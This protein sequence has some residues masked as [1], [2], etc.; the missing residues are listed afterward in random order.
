MKGHVYGTDNVL[1]LDVVHMCSAYK[2]SLS[3]ISFPRLFVYIFHNKKVQK[4][5]TKP[6]FSLV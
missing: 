6:N 2:K 1:I 5:R 3:F 4:I